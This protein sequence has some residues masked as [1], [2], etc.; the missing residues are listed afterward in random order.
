M[1]VVILAGG[2]GTRLGNETANKPKPMVQ[3]GGKPIIWHIMK[4]YSSFGYNDFIILLGYK[5]EIIK[6]YFINY[7]HYQNDIKIDLENNEVKVTKKRQEK[8][9]IELIES[10]LKTMT[11]GRLKYI[12][13]YIKGEKFFLTYGDGLAD[14]NINSLL[15]FHETH[16]KKA[17]V[18]AVQP[19]GRYGSIQFQNDELVSE[20]VEKP[21][22]DGNWMN[23]GFF[24]CEPSVLDQISG[25]ESIFEVE[26]L[27]RLAETN[28]LVAYKHDGFW[29]C[30][31]TA[32]ER[33]NLDNLWEQNKAP[34]KKW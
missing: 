32:R 25:D 30:M 15:E 20:F 12:K 18:S 33:E 22:G 3:I 2:L 5:G 23:G 31:D 19:P 24:V 27:S 1:K 17:T 11:G 8:W 34:W 4:I 29:A 9:Q 26:T 14:I 16:K 6:D 10:G 21:S 28:E 7:Y 13:D